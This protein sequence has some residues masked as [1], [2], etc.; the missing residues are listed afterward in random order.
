MTRRKA[1]LL[2][3]SDG[4]AAEV[5]EEIDLM[6]GTLKSLVH[7]SVWFQLMIINEICSGRVERMLFLLLGDFRRII[8]V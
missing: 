3:E 5:D 2:C 8:I 6:V 1:I 4:M 7:R